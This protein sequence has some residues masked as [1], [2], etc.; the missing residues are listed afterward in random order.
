MIRQN[1][2]A[3]VRWV[4]ILIC[5]NEEVDKNKFVAR[6]DHTIVLY[7]TYIKEKI[8]NLRD[9]TI[10][11]MNFYEA[12]SEAAMK[13]IRLVH[14]NVLRWLKLVVLLIWNA[15][16]FWMRVVIM[17]VLIVYAKKGL[18]HQATRVFPERKLTLVRANTS[19]AYIFI[20]N[21]QFIHF[22]H[23]LRCT[24]VLF[25]ILTYRRKWHTMYWHSVVY[26]KKY[27]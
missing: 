7:N 5:A 11:Q 16:V 25:L 2:M 27:L 23:L 6:I 18:W 3:T 1:V 13:L 17:L 24:I 20:D 10:F 9:V 26:S 19:Y 15:L 8:C 4:H 12:K 14:T 22:L 21:N